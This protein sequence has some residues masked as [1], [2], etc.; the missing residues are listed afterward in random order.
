V[1]EIGDGAFDNTP[2]EKEKEAAN[3]V[4]VAKDEGNPEDTTNKQHVKITFSGSMFR[5]VKYLALNE[6]QE[7]EAEDL[8]SEEE[9]EELDNYLHDSEYMYSSVYFDGLHGDYDDMEMDVEIN[10]EMQNIDLSNVKKITTTTS[11][12]TK[13]AAETLAAKLGLAP[14]VVDKWLKENDNIFLS[15]DKSNL[16]DSRGGEAVW[17][18][19][20]KKRESEWIDEVYE[21][22]KDYKDDPLTVDICPRSE[23]YGS[24]PQFTVFGDLLRATKYA[25]TDSILFKLRHG[26]TERTFEFDVEGEFDPNKLA[27]LY[28]ETEILDEWSDHCFAE[29][30]VY[31]GKIYETVSQDYIE[32]EIYDESAFSSQFGAIGIG[33]IDLYTGY[34]EGDNYEEM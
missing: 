8:A 7:E 27:L 20:A 24:V 2:F 25:K 14:S 11:L 17:Q 4:E 12:P 23:M 34:F 30:I 16:H 10:G 19:I 13:E 9:F 21:D 31:D 32:D 22:Y 1:T 29:Y 3:E 33:H 26:E 28:E 6:E 5:C 15:L 18:E